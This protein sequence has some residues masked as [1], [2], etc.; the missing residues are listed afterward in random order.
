MI[1]TFF[2]VLIPMIIIDGLWLGLISKS[3]Y[4]RQLGF[5]LAEKPVWIAAVLFYILYA[6]GISFFII[7][8]ALAGQLAW[9]QVLLRGLFFGVIAYATYDLT[10]HTTIAGWPLAVTIVDIIWGGVVTGL[11]TMIA[12]FILK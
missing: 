3:F 12:Y 2:A 5:L 11:S 7:A 1:K 10:N 4:S 8:P 6:T 9:W